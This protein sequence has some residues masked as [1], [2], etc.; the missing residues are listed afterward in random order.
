MIE[1]MLVDVDVNVVIATFL[2]SMGAIGTAIAFIVKLSMRVRSLEQNPLLRAFREME[3]EQLVS[4]LSNI[5][6]NSR[7]ERQNNG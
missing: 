3:H 4:A 7:V 6:S 5:L 2:V 1:T